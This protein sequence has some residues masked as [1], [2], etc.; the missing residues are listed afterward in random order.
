MQ[1]KLTLGIDVSKQTLDV[2]VKPCNV[3]FKLSNDAVGFKNLKREIK[4]LA[5]ENILIVMEHT[6]YYSLRLEKFL[7]LNGVSFC[8]IPALEIKRSLG[9]IRG[10]NDRIDARRI[11]EYGWLRRETLAADAVS[12]D[13]IGQLR[14]LLNFRS[15][16][17]ADRSG[18]MTR[19][20]EMIA[21]GAATPHDLQS[22]CQ[23]QI[24]TVL[25]QSIRKVEAEIQALIKSNLSLQRNYQL[26]KSIKGVGMIVAA[27]MI[28]FTENF[29]KFKNARKFNCYAGL[30]PFAYESG[31]SIK[32]RS[33]VSYLAN[34][35]AKTLLNLA[36]A[37]AIQHDQELKGYYQRRTSEGMKG[38]SC[39]N[40]I[41]SKIVARIFAVV[42]RQTPYQPVRSAA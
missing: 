14:S 8:K 23:R 42:K 40:I 10:K 25:T 38:M 12:D 11:A 5:S 37:S 3:H 36:A 35:Q 16:L 18:Y 4:S 26:L 31:T 33:R 15:K 1:E 29:Q 28:G 32:G 24:I 30:A 21:T 22:N 9:V 2:Y 41:R 13:D 7:T 6:G 20:K 17:V 34:K 39:L 27:Y 19:L